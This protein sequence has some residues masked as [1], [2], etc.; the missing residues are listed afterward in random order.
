MHIQ[1]PPLNLFIPESHTFLLE[2]V[3][4]EILIE[5]FDFSGVKQT[6]YL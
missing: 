3:L 4:V 1:I 6:N 2:L 5:A